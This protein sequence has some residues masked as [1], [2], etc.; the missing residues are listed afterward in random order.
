VFAILSRT[1]SPM[2]VRP[3][4]PFS[5]LSHFFPWVTP[6]ILQSVA[7]PTLRLS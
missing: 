1:V 4:I 2:R 7:C 5:A 3:T 6:F